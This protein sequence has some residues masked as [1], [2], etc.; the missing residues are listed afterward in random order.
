MPAGKRTPAPGFRDVAAFLDALDP[1]RREV[2]EALREIISDGRPELREHVKWN[3]PT[4]TAGDVDLLTINVQNR[5]H[6]VQLV[7]HRGAS[8]PEDRSRPPLISDDE[9]LVRWLSDI[10]GLIVLPDLAAVSR[11][12]AAL[13]RVVGRWIELP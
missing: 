13:D 4:Y 2:V 1:A 9:G 6:Q 12:A 11:D 10:R 8:R 7:L 5:Q 3:S